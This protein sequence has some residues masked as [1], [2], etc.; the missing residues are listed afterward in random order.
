MEEVIPDRVK[1]EL[2]GNSYLPLKVVAYNPRLLGGH[3]QFSDEVSIDS[4]I[5]FT[6]SEFTFDEHDIEVLV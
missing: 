1:T 3:L 5:R 2:L 4:G 6:P